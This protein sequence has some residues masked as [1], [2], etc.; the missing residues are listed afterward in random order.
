MGCEVEWTDILGTLG[1]VLSVIVFV[2]TRWERRKTLALDLECVTSKKFGEEAGDGDDMMI[3]LRVIN[4]GA[5]AIAIDK[6]SFEIVGPEKNVRTYET[7]WFGLENI[8]HPLKPG[9]SFEVGLF[10][11]SFTYFQG[12]GGYSKDILP[13]SVKLSDI[14]GRTYRPKSKYELLLEVGDIRRV[15]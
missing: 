1:F 7:D 9:E 5:R 10:L 11:E 13:I 12:Y 15:N 4:V 2:L 3:I 6:N 14:E 8:P